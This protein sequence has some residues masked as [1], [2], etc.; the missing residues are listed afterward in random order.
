MAQTSHVNYKL[1]NQLIWQTIVEKNIPQTQEKRNVSY[2]RQKVRLK[3]V[4]IATM[5]CLSMMPITLWCCPWLP[6]WMNE[7]E[8]KSKEREFMFQMKLKT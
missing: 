2:D 1:S 6:I 4:I 3:Y 7:N 5:V 8:K